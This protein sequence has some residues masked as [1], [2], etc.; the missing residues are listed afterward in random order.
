M[1]VHGDFTT[2]KCIPAFFDSCQLSSLLTTRD[3]S[4]SLDQSVCMVRLDGS[5]KKGRNRVD[6]LEFS[7][8]L[9]VLCDCHARQEA[10]F[11][12]AVVRSDLVSVQVINGAQLNHPG[13]TTVRSSTCLFS[14]HLQ[15]KTSASG[16]SRGRKQTRVREDL[17]Q[18]L[19]Y[20]CWMDRW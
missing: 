5:E 7:Q 20:L 10:I 1:A 11:C 17:D 9:E 3:K 8:A 2:I 15:T 19:G 6:S 14:G 12:W 16:G 4:P 13:F 18:N